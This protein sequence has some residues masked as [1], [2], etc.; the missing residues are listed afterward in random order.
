M[1]F[2]AEIDRICHRVVV[3][4]EINRRYLQD[5][6]TLRNKFPQGASLLNAGKLYLLWKETGKVDDKRKSSE[7]PPVK[8]ESAIKDEDREFVRLAKL[9]DAPLVTNDSPLISQGRK[10]SLRVMN[11]SEALE[12]A[13]RT[14]TKPQAPATVN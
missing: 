4:D 7:L 10:L 3:T 2:L 13:L 12:M 6:H 8:G 5:Y 11:I 1:R 9:I 14:Q